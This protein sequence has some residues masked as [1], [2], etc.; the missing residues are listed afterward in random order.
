MARRISPAHSSRFGGARR[1]VACGLLLASAMLASC[2]SDSERHFV[3][4]IDPDR[5]LAS[6]SLEESTTFC[7]AAEVYIDVLYSIELTNR[8]NCLGDSTRLGLTDGVAAC[9]ASLDECVATAPP[10]PPIDRD[11]ENASPGRYPGCTATIDEIERCA[12]A[13][14]GEVARLLW[15]MDCERALDLVAE[16]VPEL[17]FEQSVADLEA[18]PCARVALVCPTF[19]TAITLTGFVI[20]AVEP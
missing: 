2:A 13:A 20:G 8:L 12:D 15:P 5:T 19:Y 4:G 18:G 3:A 1:Y 14:Y 10:L 11:C 17:V 6:L 7:E 9:Q 16:P